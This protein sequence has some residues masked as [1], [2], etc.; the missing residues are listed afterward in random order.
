M[1]RRQR[2]GNGRG[3]TEERVGR[4]TTTTTK[5]GM[6][7]GQLR[8]GLEGRQQQKREWKGDN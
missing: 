7:G 5:E 1:G 6:K 3:T 8:T 4:E 2:R